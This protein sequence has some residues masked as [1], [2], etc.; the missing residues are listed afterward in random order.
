MVPNN[1]YQSARKALNVAKKLLHPLAL[2]VLPRMIQPGR[3][4]TQEESAENA[5]IAATATAATEWIVILV[6]AASFCV[7]CDVGVVVVVVLWA[8]R[9]T[10]IWLA[11]RL[12]AGMTSEKVCSWYTETLFDRRVTTGVVGDGALNLT[13]FPAFHV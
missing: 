9:P 2:S 4:K 11:R 3:K 8:D 12:Q 10:D 1:K 7:G 13:G 6:V 5:T